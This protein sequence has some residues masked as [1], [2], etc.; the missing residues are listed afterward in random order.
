MAQ[1]IAVADAFDAMTSDR[2]YRDGMPL[3]RVLG[4]FKDGIGVQW[5]PDVATLLV[6]QIDTLFKLVK[7]PRPT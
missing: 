2:P 7:S 4:I 1:I 6:T 5:A 3:D